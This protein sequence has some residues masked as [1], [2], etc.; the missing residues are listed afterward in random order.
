MVVQYCSWK[1][2]CTSWYGDYP[3]FHGVSQI[4]DGAGF[5]PS[6]VGS[7]LFSFPTFA[8]RTAS[9]S[10][11]SSRPRCPVKGPGWTTC[12]PIPTSSPRRDYKTYKNNWK[13][14][15]FNQTSSL[16][17]QSPSHLIPSLA[18]LLPNKALWAFPTTNP[19]PNS[20]NRGNSAP[21]FPSWTLDVQVLWQTKPSAENAPVAPWC[22]RDC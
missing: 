8:P 15:C 7:S 18:N 3:I 22:R 20:G 5:L 17:V 2:S 6:T 4:T 13:H 10:C 21:F 12:F 19:Q 9:N 1:K 11:S 16:D 14:R